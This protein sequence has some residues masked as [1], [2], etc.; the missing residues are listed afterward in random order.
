MDYE[1]KLNRM[2]A[3]ARM[4]GS[5]K[6]RRAAPGKR[7][8][9]PGSSYSEIF[10]LYYRGEGRLGDDNGLTLC[11]LKDSRLKRRRR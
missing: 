10:A 3:K 4:L 5:L 11:G 6:S 2:A 7:P 8:E 1:E 9:G